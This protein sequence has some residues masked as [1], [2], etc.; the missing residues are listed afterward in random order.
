MSA[1]AV[2]TG[3]LE[4]QGCHQRRVRAARTFS[5]NRARRAAVR[6]FAHSRYASTGGMVGEQKARAS[7]ISLSTI[8]STHT[9]ATAQTDVPPSHGGLDCYCRKLCRENS[10]MH[11]RRSARQWGIVTSNA[12]MTFA[13]ART[14][15]SVFS[16]EEGG[17]G[18]QSGQPSARGYRPVRALPRGLLERVRTKSFHRKQ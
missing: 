11:C 1:G 9:S 5:G 8:A 17:Q 14:E 10:C 12:P 6:V 2:L 13:F 3:S 7:L 18:C 15:S 4:L 16:R